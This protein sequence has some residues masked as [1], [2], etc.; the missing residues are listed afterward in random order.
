M[1]PNHPF[2]R[3]QGLVKQLRSDILLVSPATA[4]SCIGL[5]DGMFHVSRETLEEYAKIET[6]ENDVNASD[7]NNAAYILFTSGSTGKPKGIIV[8]HL[9]FTTSLLGDI[10][11]FGYQKSIRMFQFGIYTFDASLTEI[12]CTLLCGG[13]LCIPSDDERMHGATRFITEN[14]CNTAVLTPSFA[15]TLNPA[16]LSCLKNLLVCGEPPGKDTIKTW[17]P[18][19][20]LI[21]GYGPSEAII[22]SSYNV[23]ESVDSSPTTIGRNVAHYSWIVDP[24]DHHKLRPIGSIGE[25]LIQGHCIARGYLDDPERTSD[26]FVSSAAWLPESMSGYPQRFYKTGDLAKFNFDGTIEYCGRKDL[27]VKIRGQRLELGEIEDTMLKSA[28]SL[29]KAVADAIKVDGR[30]TLVAFVTFPDHNITN[31]DAGQGHFTPMTDTLKKEISKLDDALK[32]KLPGYMVP[33]YYLPMS[34]MPVLASMKT[35]R[36]KLKSYVADMTLSQL[37]T[38][39]IQS[40]I[41][42]EPVSDMEY[43]LREIWAT[44]L[45]ISPDEISRHDSFLRIGGDSISAIHL[46]SLA[47]KKGIFLTSRAIFKDS[48]LDRMAA[49]C[50]AS[51]AAALAEVEPFSLVPSNSREALLSE[52]RK[53]CK[54]PS[55]KVIEDIFPCTTLQEGMMSLTTRQPRSHI[56][57]HLYFIPKHVDLAR[58][59]SAWERTIQVCPNMRTRIVFIQGKTY[60]VVIQ[61]DTQW[62]T[63]AN[64][65][66]ANC[67]IRD[68]E[69]NYGSTLSRY[70]FIETPRGETYLAWCVHHAVF[71]GWSLGIILEAMFRAYDGGEMPSIRNFANFIMYTEKLNDDESATYWK[72]ELSGASR[73]SFPPPLRTNS[74]GKTLLLKHTIDFANVPYQGITKASILRAAWAIILARYSGTDDIT[75]GASISG[76]QAAV[77]GIDR[78]PGPVLATIPVRV[79]IN[80]ATN[81]VEFVQS[82]QSKLLI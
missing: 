51:D 17:V 59:K 44:I 42:V 78:I 72:R 32:S 6:S 34:T 64:V 46:V 27:Q 40:R 38:F 53:Q 14:Q 36:K 75:F 45:K 50:Q 62:E 49:T 33:D 77:P 8:E 22:Y 1:D 35:D 39:S 20:K 21:N 37:N 52:A 30:Q 7:P 31:H 71:D 73:A 11:A 12:F 66:T 60:Q 48:R 61:D 82:I 2:D 13:V 54:L 18:Y 55:E 24:D 79:V 74:A 67:Q 70:A 57:R 25:L 23:Y 63:E 58:L 47:E 26:S 19:L 56:G 4:S 3:R 29:E 28:R 9:G 69:M 68:V 76:R 15:R 16:D 65:D 10:R 5:S 80:K 41:Y 43:K 81:V